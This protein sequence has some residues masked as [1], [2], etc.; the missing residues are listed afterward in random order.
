MQFETIALASLGQGDQLNM[1]VYFWYLVKSDLSSERYHVRTRKTRPCLTGHPVL[2]WRSIQQATHLSDL[3]PYG[4][5][6]DEDDK[7][8]RC[9]ACYAEP[10]FL[11]FY[12]H[13]II[14]YI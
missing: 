6:R 10:Y 12:K 11:H 7:S 1:V 8:N 4:S 14:Y 9:A 2:Y 3:T 13:F 5:V